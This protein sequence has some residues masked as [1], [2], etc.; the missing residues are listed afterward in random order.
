MDDYEVNTNS[1]DVMFEL[2]RWCNM[3][4]E[5]CVRGTRQRKR[6]TQEN[7]RLVLNNFDRISSIMFSGGEPAL[8][9]DLMEYTLE[10]CKHHRIR[11]G[12]FWMA[13]NGSVVSKRFLNCIYDWFEYCD[14]NDISGLRISLDPFHEGISRKSLLKF[15]GLE[16]ELQ[17]MGYLGNHGFELSTESYSLVKQGRAESLQTNLTLREPDS[18]LD[19]DVALGKLYVTGTIYVGVNGKYYESCSLSYK[20]QDELKLMYLGDIKEDLD[21]LLKQRFED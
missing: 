13:T 7:I 18:D 21:Y 2:T 8:A 16:Q 5:H 12:N 14:D 6:Q 19:S 17:Y 11:I 15:K 9:L 3:E 1:L 4:C 10:Y 20:T